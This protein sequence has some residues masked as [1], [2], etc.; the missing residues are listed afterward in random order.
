[1]ILVCY[2]QKF[3]LLLPL[4]SLGFGIYLSSLWKTSSSIGVMKGLRFLEVF[5][6]LGLIILVFSR[7]SCEFSILNISK[8]S[9]G[10]G[11]RGDEL[12]SPILGMI[13]ILSC[14]IFKYSISYL[15]GD[16]NR[17]TFFRNYHLTVF[18]VVLLV[19]ANN[20]VLFFIAWL[21]ISYGL[22]YLLLYFPNR[23][24]AVLAAKKKWFVSRI[25]DF[26]L[27]IAIILTFYCFKTVNFSEL[28]AFSHNQNI[29]NSIT[30]NQ[31]ISLIGIFIVIG[32]LAKSAQF[33]F[34]FWLPE[35]M[36]T[37]TPVSA[38]MH[39]G[40]INGGGYLVL[41]L[42]PL[43][44]HAEF[45]HGLLIF[46]GGLSAVLG[47][48]IFA[49]QTD[50][51]QKLAYSTISQLGFMMIECGLGAYSF[52]LFHMIAHGFYKANAFL[53]SPSALENQSSCLPELLKKNI[54]Q[55]F[56]CFFIFSINYA[57][58]SL[59][60]FIGIFIYLFYEL[61]IEKKLQF[62]FPRYIHSELFYY[63][64][65]LYLIILFS[66]G[67]YI[68]NKIRTNFNLNSQKIWL[69]LRNGLYF[70]TLSE[71]IFKR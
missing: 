15:E 5:G 53:S 32:S 56:K 68:L 70:H 40:I 45:A 50:V 25:G 60:F 42:S 30:H 10:I 43:L 71:R 39:A 9:E 46:F 66:S 34:H 2:V 62:I 12:S 35:T 8:F 13:L 65:F 18:F 38:L 14:S 54:I 44:I 41:R 49:V 64:S 63:L 33:P 23:R 7:Q 57:R 59:C 16:K 29:L 4:I 37:P 20:L 24:K 52:A 55:K 3:L 6:A 48:L 17:W 22:H 28:I 47:S 58:Y 26:S 11:L 1:M 21:G 31:Y 69:L 36:E 51:K 67:L 61:Y 19:L 27:F